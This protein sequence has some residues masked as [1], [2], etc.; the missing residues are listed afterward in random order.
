MRG[1]HTIQGAHEMATLVAGLLACERLDAI[2]GVA[3]IGDRER[4]SQQVTERRLRRLMI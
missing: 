2:A 1:D 4:R 3:G